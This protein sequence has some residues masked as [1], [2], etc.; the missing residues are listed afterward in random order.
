MTLMQQYNFA[1]LEQ[2]VRTA[3]NVLFDRDAFL[4]QNNVNERSISHKLAE[5]LQSEFED[6][7]VDCEYNRNHDARKEIYLQGEA[8]SLND[9]DARTVFPDIIVH[10]RNTDD[11]LLVIEIKKSTSTVSSDFDKRKLQAFTSAPFYYQF[12][13]FLRFTTG[14]QDIHAY[15]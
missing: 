13:L 12:G 15:Q 9:T 8:G 1:E 14:Q 2:R 4:L 7:N 5:Y 6:W 10:R 3:I 11:N